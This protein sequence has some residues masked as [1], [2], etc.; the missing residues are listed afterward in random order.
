MTIIEKILQQLKDQ[1]LNLLDDL[2]S[3]CPKESDILF[4]R[5]YFENSMD[6]QELMDGFIKWVL[7][8]K[9]QILSNDETF[10]TQNDHIFGPI[11]A[12][13]IGHFKTKF[14]DGTFDKSDKKVIFSYFVVFISL[15]EQYNKLK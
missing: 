11:P 9:K 6:S 12:N 10:F 7:P 1:V 3:I 5:L 15:I 4:V 13:K 8:W 2:I 14:L